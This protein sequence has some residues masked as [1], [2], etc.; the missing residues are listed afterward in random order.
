MFS[1]IAPR[2]DLLNHLLTLNLD[3]RWRRRAV[4]RLGWESNPRGLFLDACA[5][6][7]DLALTLA[8]EPEFRGRVAASDFALPMLRRGAPKAR[9]TAVRP[10][11]ADALC[12]PFEDRVFDGAMVG[13]G[14]RNL[15]NLTAGFTELRRVLKP[16]ARLVVLDSTS[17]PPSVLRPL[18]RLYFERL[19]PV[20]GRAVSGHPTAYSYLPDSVAAF[21]NAAE[22]GAIMAESGFVDCGFELL[23]AGCVA[24]HWGA[25]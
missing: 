19:V 18:A 10:A 21:P 20:V 16:G 4:R 6:T 15:S 1:A 23:A 9:G 11:A 7:L 14:M 25:R 3:R 17:P 22:L 8:S 2:Y 13:W 12:L 24:I 5:G